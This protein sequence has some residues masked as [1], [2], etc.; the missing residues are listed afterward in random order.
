MRKNATIMMLS[1]IFLSSAFVLHQTM[2]QSTATISVQTVQNQDGTYTTN[3]TVSDVTG[4]FAWQIGLFYKS[5]ILSVARAVEGPFLNSDGEQ[6]TFILSNNS[7]NH[8]NATY[9]YVL[10]AD[11]RTYPWVGINGSGTLA[12]V[13][14]NVVASGTSPLHLDISSAFATELDDASGNSIPFTAVDGVVNAVP[15]FPS[16]AI[17]PLFMMA[18][19]VSLVALRRWKKTSAGAKQLHVLAL[20]WESLKSD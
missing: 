2:G 6:T 17:V 3:I 9:G 12:T 18:T 7:T 20:R 4:L 10:M 5:S 19:I 8:Y 1:I 11:S 13:T 14:F 16:L 15:E